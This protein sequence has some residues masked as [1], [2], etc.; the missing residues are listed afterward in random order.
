[1]SKQLDCTFCVPV[2]TP[3]APMRARVGE[4]Q[5]SAAV[6]QLAIDELA[7]DV[8]NIVEGDRFV[9]Y[10]PTRTTF[11]PSPY[12]KDWPCMVPNYSRVPNCSR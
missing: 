3:H 12:D 9:L 7:F 6:C 2:E 11:I 8:L 10:G 5:D 4:F 1:M